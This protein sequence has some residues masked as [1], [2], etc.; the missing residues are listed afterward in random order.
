MK[1]NLLLYACFFVNIIYGQADVKR[2]AP[3]NRKI[4]IGVNFSTDICYRQIINS[5]DDAFADLIIKS[6]NNSEVPKIGFH[7]GLKFMYQINQNISFESG[8]QFASRGYQTRN[9][10]MIYEDPIGGVNSV[11]NDHSPVKIRIIYNYYFIDIPLGLNFTFGK[12]KVRFISSIGLNVNYFIKTINTAVITYSDGETERHTSFVVKKNHL[13]I[14]NLSPAMG[15]GIVYSLRDNL[16]L[17]IESCFSYGLMPIQT[18]PVRD[19]L[20]NGGLN[21]AINYRL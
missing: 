21:M 16:F 12:K 2:V 7:T 5:T 4:M 18:S 9:Q 6:R 11:P 8:I 17:R 20:Y 14:I 19:F 3:S 1:W 10:N 13:Q 15:A